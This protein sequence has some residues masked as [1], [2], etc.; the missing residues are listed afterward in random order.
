MA[1]TK[2]LSTAV[3]DGVGTYS[4]RNRI[5]N[6][7]M[8]IDQRN[9]GSA[10]TLNTNSDSF[11]VDRFECEQ[12]AITVNNGT[13][14]RVADAPTGFTYSFK[15]TA[16]SSI[17]FNSSLGWSGI[18]QRIEGNNL[19]DL[20]WGTSSAKPV[21]LSFWVKSSLTGLFTINMTHYDGTNERWNNVT[22][23]INSANTWEY[24]T[25]TF[26][27]DQTYGIPNDNGATGWMRVY[28]MLGDNAGGSSTTT[29]FNTWFAGT[30]S[31]RGASGQTNLIST[32]GATFYLTGVQLEVGSAASPFERRPYGTE[33]AL[34]QRY[35][36]KSY[37]TATAPGSATAS[38]LVVVGTYASGIFTWQFSV[39]F[40]IQMRGLPT[41]S[42]WDGAGTLSRV[43]YLGNG[44]TTWNN[45]GNPTGTIFNIS[46]SGFLFN[47]NT[48]TTATYFVHYAAN[49]E[50]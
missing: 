36:C 28:W 3:S 19:S 42:Y 47:Y 22:Y 12:G 24:K 37:E 7:D 6:G 30:A 31:K 2:A 9:N 27:G 23:T 10:V 18:N 14:Q 50:L 15:Y 48:S 45:G 21:T 25:I 34:C 40:P 13:V 20:A 17:T 26:N 39:P 8:R 29:S 4:F 46:A 16:A 49:A 35:Y 44:T 41:V 38:G 5:I 32:S 43:S 1:I 33:L 11:A